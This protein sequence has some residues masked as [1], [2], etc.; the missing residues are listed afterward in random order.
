MTSGLVSCFLPALQLPAPA[1]LLPACSPGCF[2]RLTLL[3][4][5]SGAHWGASCSL[6]T[7]TL[8]Y[9]SLRQQTPSR[10]RRPVPPIAPRVSQSRLPLPLP[11]SP[12]PPSSKPAPYML[13]RQTQEDG[14]AHD[15]T[16]HQA[17]RHL[18]GGPRR[19]PGT[20]AEAG[21]AIRGKEHLAAQGKVQA[22]RARLRAAAQPRDGPHDAQ[23]R[24]LA[25]P[26]D[27]S[28]AAAPQEQGTVSGGD[29]GLCTDTRR[30]TL[31]RVPETERVVDSVWY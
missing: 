12:P 1:L 8:P 6:F 5:A 18:A 16:V 10:R 4:L 24:G 26:S 15:N 2:H 7:L 13:S 14:P 22:A 21:A 29:G 25:Q 23:G 30:N 31:K 27:H 20:D 9:F 28:H 17:L 11:P 3:A 19:Q